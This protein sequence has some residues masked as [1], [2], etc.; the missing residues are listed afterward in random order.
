MPITIAHLFLKPARHQPVVEQSAITLTTGV[1]IAGDIHAHKLN[2]RQVLVTLAAQLDA[3]AVAPGA[4]YENLVITGAAPADFRP[5]SAIVIGDV[6]IRL[7]MYCEPCR[8]IAPLVGNLSLI[9]I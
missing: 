6:E 7:T 4:L 1:G 5:G 3:L 2:P 8:R 9:H